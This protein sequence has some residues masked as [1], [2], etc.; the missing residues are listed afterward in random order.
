MQLEQRV[1][2]ATEEQMVNYFDDLS[3]RGEVSAMQRLGREL[4]EAR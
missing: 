2:V 3:L 1:S 4:G